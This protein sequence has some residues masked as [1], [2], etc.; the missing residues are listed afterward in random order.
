MRPLEP[1]EN[2]ILP[3]GEHHA[4]T[5]CGLW[6]RGANNLDVVF[7]F[8]RMGDDNHNVRVNSW[9]KRC[10]VLAKKGED[11]R[12]RLEEAHLD[13]LERV[14]GTFPGVVY[15]LAAP[16][17]GVCKVGYTQ[18]HPESRRKTGQTWAPAPLL[19]VG[20]WGADYFGETEEHASLDESHEHGE[21]FRL[22]VDEARA[23]VLERGGELHQVEPGNDDQ[24][25]EQ[26]LLEG[27]AS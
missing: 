11:N 20:Y 16:A 8:R 22:S 5:H 27:V 1:H 23:L 26:L 4:C 19:L 14:K 24:Q 21:W 6:A 12:P 25:H 10:R 3:T 17:L 7:G 13:Q 9:C 18:A 15:V 2:L